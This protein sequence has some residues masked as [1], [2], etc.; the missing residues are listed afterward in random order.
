MGQFGV[1]FDSGTESHE[2]KEVALSVDERL[3]HNLFSWSV[4]DKN[5]L[6]KFSLNIEVPHH[7]F[8]RHSY[9]IDELGSWLC[10]FEKDPVDLA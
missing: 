10:I 8:I 1:L 4:N 6:D 7:L 5:I 9:Q 2:S 3:L